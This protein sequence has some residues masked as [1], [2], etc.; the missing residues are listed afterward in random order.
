MT[1]R[2]SSA[3]TPTAAGRRR[4]AGPGSPCAR[5]CDRTPVVAV[6]AVVVRPES[7]SRGQT[8]ANSQLIPNVNQVHRL[9]QSRRSQSDSTHRCDKSLLIRTP[10]LTRR[11]RN[12]PSAQIRQTEPNRSLI[13][14]S[15]RRWILLP[16]RLVT[17]NARC[18]Y[19]I[20]F[21]S[22]ERPNETNQ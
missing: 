17:T 5:P 22:S 4:C 8:Y 20:Q 14:I 21:G 19:C 13:I 15:R 6:V 11:V 16:L 18:C 9:R 2:G 10:S 7:L 3:P 1:V 12:S